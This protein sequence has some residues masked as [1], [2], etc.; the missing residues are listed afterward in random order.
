MW[1]NFVSGFAWIIQKFYEAT[2]LVGI[3]NFGVA[4]I[5]ITIAMKILLYPLTAKQMASVKAM[6]EIQPQIKKLQEKHK[7]NPEKAQKAIM[8]LYRKKRINPLAGCLPLLIQ[9]PIL[10]AFYQALYRIKDIVTNLQLDPS[11]LK[12]LWIADITNP[13][14][15]LVVGGQAYPIP[16]LPVLAA[17]TTFW[18]QRVSITSVNDP[19]QRAMLY[20]MPLFLG[21]ISYKLPA[22]LALYWVMF[23]I[24]GA[25]QQMYV[26]R[27][28][29]GKETEEVPPEEE[30]KKKKGDKDRS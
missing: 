20:T 4:I 30:G 28:Q 17:A 5:F 21:W 27:T 18:Q 16:I 11:A 6:Q 1:G 19:T 25:L 29:A 22:G 23:S 12:F 8:E 14:Q 2:A 26:N 24:L 7:K 3:A 15:S 13:D 9:M 10:I